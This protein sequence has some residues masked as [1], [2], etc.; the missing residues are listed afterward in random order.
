M[1][2]LSRSSSSLAVFSS[3]VKGLIISIDSSKFVCSLV[4]ELANHLIANLTPEVKLT[5]LWHDIVHVLHLKRV[6]RNRSI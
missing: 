2:N 3:S 6:Y 4:S 1:V 5:S